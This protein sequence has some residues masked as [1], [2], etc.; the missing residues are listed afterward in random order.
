M[1][2]FVVAG[3]AALALVAVAFSTVLAAGRISVSLTEQGAQH[4]HPELR[5]G[6]L[7]VNPDLASLVIN[8]AQLDKRYLIVF[9]AHDTTSTAQNSCRGFPLVTFNAP[10][11][12]NAQGNLNILLAEGWPANAPEVLDVRVT[13]TDLDIDGNPTV[14]SSECV[15]ITVK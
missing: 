12:T 2:R 7:I 10:R 4:G 13:L 9:M 5:A 14:Y 11:E 15:A 3:V 6:H 1:C 8:G